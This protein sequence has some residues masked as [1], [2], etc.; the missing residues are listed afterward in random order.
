[1]SRFLIVS[2]S[3]LLT[4]ISAM[5]ADE[6]FPYRYLPPVIGG[7]SIEKLSSVVDVDG[8]G[9]L[10]FVTDPGPVVFLRQPDGSFASLEPLDGLFSLTSSVVAD[11][12]FD[13]TPDVL[14]IWQS[15]DGDGF[16]MSY[17]SNAEGT[18]ELKDIEY[19]GH[20]WL[21][22]TYR[23]STIC[24]TYDSDPFLSFVNVVQDGET[25]YLYVRRV[26]PNGRLS[27][28]IPRA[29]PVS[30]GGPV[31]AKV[32]HIGSYGLFLINDEGETVAFDQLASIFDQSPFDIVN[33]G[34]PAGNPDPVDFDGDGLAELVLNDGQ[35]VRVY[36]RIDQNYEVWLEYVAEESLRYLGAG[37]YDNDGEME[38]FIDSDA[39]VVTRNSSTCV[40]VLENVANQVL[41]DGP[42]LATAREADKVEI[43]DLN[44]DGLNDLAIHSGDGIM[45][46]YADG[47]AGFL[48][49]RTVY[50]F[51]EEGSTTIAG[52]LAPDING[53]GLS[54]A[55]TRA[56]NG[57]VVL[58]LNVG[59][60]GLGPPITIT[61]F[62]EVREL[63]FA[64]MNEDGELDLV[65]ATTDN[66]VGVGLGHG[67]GQFGPF[68]RYP[69]NGDTRD[70]DVGDLNGDGHLD[71]VVTCRFTNSITTYYGAGDGTLNSRLDVATPV[72]PVGVAVADLNDDGLDD[73]VTAHN[74]EH[75]LGVLLRS[76]STAFAPFKTIEMP[77]ANLTPDSVRLV[78]LDLDGS[79][80]II[81]PYNGASIW[82]GDSSGEF[83]SPTY[84]NIGRATL[85]IAV[86][87]IDGDTLPDILWVDHPTQH[88]VTIARNLGNRQFELADRFVTGGQP[89]Q[90]APGDF[91][92]VGDLDLLVAH[93]DQS[94]IY[95]SNNCSIE[96]AVRGDAN[97]DGVLTMDDI[98]GF[99]A[100]LVNQIGGL[101]A[102]KATDMNADGVNDGTDIGIFVECLLAGGC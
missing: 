67:D 46:F 78:D 57:S 91:D 77:I 24:R 52:A 64:D 33:P 45:L 40:S 86:A 95:F 11:I 85:Q 88:G 61:E 87:D 55:V 35:T 90:V 62:P 48:G 73:V 37:D 76:T 70:V 30:A 19:V 68:M 14:G 16:F 27:P 79:I 8:D 69:V 6:C 97:G 101:S 3:L 31:V 20:G 5:R 89:Y 102:R 81:A 41:T 60:G 22:P 58:R 84:V 59:G 71:T 23:G 32:N 47:L 96:S 9:F 29:L 53:D 12:N 92:G 100:I 1:M 13:S 18:L 36:K 43:A 21:E 65:Y 2:A 50:D 17:L 51:R 4:A 54:D 80:D 38:L 72:A 83:G 28:G 7:E 82:F 49:P 74:S 98:P 66:K 75:L 15:Y 10:D 26:Q 44:A 34:F 25:S 63:R 99:V 94:S 42:E 93:R 39:C 56:G